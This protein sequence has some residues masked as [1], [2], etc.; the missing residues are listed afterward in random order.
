M[1][2]KTKGELLQEKLLRKPE[3]G[4]ICLSESELEKAS[5]FCNGYKNFLDAS[6]TEREA[7]NYAIQLLQKYGYREHSPG[8]KYQPGDKIYYNNRGK[9]LVFATMGTKPIVEGI[10]LAASH[11]DSPRIDLKPCPLYEDSQIAYFK[12]HYYGGIKKYQWTTIPLALHGVVIKKDQTTVPV[13]IGEAEDD[14]VFCITDLLPHLDKEQMQRKLEDGIKGEELNIL[15]GSLPFRDDKASEKVK[16]NIANILFEK[17]GILEEDFLS[18]ELTMVP[19]FKAKDVGLDRSMVGAYGHDDRVCAYT[20]LMAALESREPVYTNVTVLT[21]REEIGSI[22]NTGLRS[23]YLENFIADL[24]EP[25][26]VPVRWVLSNTQCLS[27]DVNC[28]LDPTFADVSER[29]NSA[30][31]NYGVVITKYTG[32]GG[33]SGTS[34]A[35]AEFMA[36]LRALYDR[37]GVLWQVGELGKVDQGGGGTVAQFIADLN[38]DVV[39]VGV[40]VLSMHAPYELV[41]KIDV[42]ETYRAFY[43]FLSEK[44]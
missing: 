36:K 26:G 25:W 40:P 24:A 23:A 11:I 5:A 31:L 33:K 19:A 38:V 20:S 27:A 29:R 9:A 42:Y 37:T 41:S 32:H 22:G 17:Y 4:G 10:R 14:P 13:S 15:I 21:D 34:E 3:Q 8:E 30:Y 18:A 39:D 7:V 1:S 2:E 12:T 44:G 35:S 16:L 43:E 6:K 28:A